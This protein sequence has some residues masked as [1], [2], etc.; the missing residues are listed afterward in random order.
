MLTT[1]DFSEADL[2]PVNASLLEKNPQSASGWPTIFSSDNR[3][4]HEQD[5]TT[6]THSLPKLA[7]KETK[8]SVSISD[9]TIKSRYCYCNRISYGTMIRCEN[10]ACPRE[11]FHISCLKPDNVPPLKGKWFCSDECKESKHKDN[12][13]WIERPGGSLEKALDDLMDRNFPSRR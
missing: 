12:V 11:L 3:R 6:E 5:S 2:A 9:D 7:T 4:T 13:G 8:T 1:L 10:Y